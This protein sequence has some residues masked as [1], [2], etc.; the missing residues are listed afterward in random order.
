SD[1]LS[2]LDFGFGA[3]YFLGG[4]ILRP[5]KDDFMFRGLNESELIVSQFMMLNLGAQINPIKNIYIT[6]HFN[7][8]TISYDSFDDYIK[9]AF[10]PQGNWSE[11][12]STS[13]VV[14]AGLTTSYMSLIGPID[15]DFSWIN[16]INKIRFFV[17]IGFQFNRSN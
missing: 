11:E 14:S 12:N 13:R 8:A 16:D 17:G 9:D 6:P 15:M 10:N 5:R 7:I 4:N 3:K 1:N 2:Y